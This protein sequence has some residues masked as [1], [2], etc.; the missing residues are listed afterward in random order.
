VVVGSTIPTAPL[1]G[2]MEVVEVMVVKALT[3]VIS[4]ITVR[5]IIISARR[6]IIIKS[7]LLVQGA[8]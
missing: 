3:V 6:T 7:Y 1:L 8:R 4:H 5:R 2:I